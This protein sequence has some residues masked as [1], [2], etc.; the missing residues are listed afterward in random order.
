MKRLMLRHAFQFV[1][2]VVFLIGPQNLRSQKAIEKLGGV[3]VGS[4]ADAAGRDSYVYE[5]TSLP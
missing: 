3:H 2:R 4:R 5:I 1:K